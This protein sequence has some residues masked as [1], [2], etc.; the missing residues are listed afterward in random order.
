MFWDP[1]LESS[2]ISLGP[3]N[4]FENAKCLLQKA[5][6]LTCFQDNKK[7]NDSSLTN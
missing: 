6:L 7:Q 5:D 4:Y 2:D 1:F 3:K